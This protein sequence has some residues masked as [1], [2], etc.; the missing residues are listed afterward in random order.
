M[1]LSSDQKIGVA[2]GAIG[3]AKKFFSPSAGAEV[4]TSN[5]PFVTFTGANGEKLTN[6]YR[7]KIRVPPR[8]LDYNLTKGPDNIL[9]RNGGIVFPYTPQISYETSAAYANMNVLHSNYPV[10]SYKHSTVG[11]INLTAK[12]TVQNDRDAGVYLAVTQLLRGLTKMSVGA[13][14]DA[15]TPPPV[16][17]LD[18]YGGHMLNN[19]PV[20]IASFRLDYPDNVDYYRIE[21]SERGGSG[22]IYGVNFVPTSSQIVLSLLPM[23][24]R[25]EQIAYRRSDF[26]DGRLTGTGTLGKGYL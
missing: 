22:D 5:R 3:L 6:D 7:A 13:E 19:V 24:S 16:C 4:A 9:Q 1:A 2:L 15:G 20:V 14:P 26:L 8:F 18:A 23:Y 17:R 11:A 25:K 21:Y 10:Y 12:F